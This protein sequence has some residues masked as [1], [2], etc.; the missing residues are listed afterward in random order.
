MHRPVWITTL[1]EHTGYL[2]TKNIKLASRFRYYWSLVK[3]CNYTT[4]TT[5]LRIIQVDEA[6]LLDEN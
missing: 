2:H 6:K 1:A 4:T 3:K 5:P